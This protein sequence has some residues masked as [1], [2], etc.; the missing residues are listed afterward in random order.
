MSTK[1]DTQSNRSAFIWIGVGVVVVVGLF[2][3]AIASG[4]A[5]S[6]TN[7]FEVAAFGDVEVDGSLPALDPANVG[8]AEFDEAAGLEVPV[9]S[10][11]DYNGE[12]SSIGDS[13]EPQ[14]VAFLAHWCPHC[15]REVPR[16]VTAMDGGSTI[17][18]LPIN[19]DAAHR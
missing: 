8:I 10:G 17:N 9:A 4:G 5:T 3:W 19:K 16:L 12:P 2:V 13:G 14:I 1:S 11:T 15:Q 7:S 18:A 6:S